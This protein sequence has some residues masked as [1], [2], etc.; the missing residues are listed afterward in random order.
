MNIDPNDRMAGHPILRVRKLLGS[1]LSVGMWSATL[2]E[3]V[4]GI[5]SDA[6]ASVMRSLE[7]DGYV[8]T[9]SL[10]GDTSFWTNTIKGNELAKASAAK[11]LLRRTAEKR[12]REFL[13]R[14]R[15]VRDS[16]H[17]TYAVSKAVVFGSYLT[18][19]ERIS[20]ID[21]AIELR[22]KAR[23]AEERGKLH[24]EKVLEALR[25][26]RRFDSSMDEL[27]W[28]QW[29][30]W[31]YLKN[32]SRALDLQPLHMEQLNVTGGQT[33]YEDASMEVE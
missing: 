16:P 19:K 33:I 24:E 13:E 5:D 3:Y 9:A 4:L 27:I 8:E 29:E 2:T 31:L 14:V 15:H 21:I 28:P 30:V 11:P 20:D 18:P 25:S 32:R 7:R 12:M 10:G 22:S 23:D 26:G 17:F 6:A 1:G